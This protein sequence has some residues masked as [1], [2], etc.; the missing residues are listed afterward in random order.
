MERQCHNYKRLKKFSLRFVY[1]AYVDVTELLA[2]G[3]FI[4][5]QVRVEFGPE[6][7]NSREKYHIIVCRVKKRDVDRFLSAVE[8]LPNKMLLFGHTDYI[9]YCNHIWDELLDKQ[10]GRG[11]DAEISPAQKAEQA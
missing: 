1:F 9:D 4:R 8:E 10:K 5:H 7:Y 3:L 2:D 6:F 11:S